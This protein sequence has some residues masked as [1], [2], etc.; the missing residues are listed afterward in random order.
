MAFDISMNAAVMTDNRKNKIHPH[1]FTL[2]VG[3]GSILMMFAGLTSAYILKRNMA[4]WQG[5]DLPTAFWY[6]TA[7]VA[8]SSFTLWRAT[9]AF[10]QREMPAY[11]KL[12]IATAFLGLLFIALQT[13]GFYELIEQ[14]NAL[15]VKN[16]VDFLYVI[17]GIHAVHVLAGVIVLIVMLLKAFSS[18]TRSY[19]SV[20]I[21]LAATYWHF[22]G[23]LWIY[24]LVFLV[25]I[26]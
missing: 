8:L 24:L 21:E 11:R 18:K 5:Y 25:L 3:I 13:V 23:I 14:G 20:P 17:V 6:S 1:K 10:K 19:S 22:V 26:R 16:S 2:W 7:V 15:G 4:N 9:I 12:M